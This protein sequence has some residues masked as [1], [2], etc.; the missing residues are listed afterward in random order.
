M[1]DLPQPHD[2]QT[3]NIPLAVR[4]LRSLLEENGC[5]LR[6]PLQVRF[7]LPIKTNL[8]MNLCPHLPLDIKV[9]QV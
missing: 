7:A 4:D 2:P 6:F 1:L 3:L 9:N 5:P 8:N